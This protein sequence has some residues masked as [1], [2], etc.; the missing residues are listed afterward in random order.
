MEASSPSVGG[1]FT[2][3]AEVLGALP[4]VCHFF[5]RLGIDRRLDGAVA[6]SDPR[7]R[8][9]PGKALGV[10]VRN[11][12]LAHGPIY[13]LGEWAGRH[14]P[15]LLG[16]EEAE[17]ALVGDDRV[18]RA[19]L[20]LFDADRATMLN[21][22]VLDAVATFG[23]DVSQLHNDSTTVRLFGA[24]RDAKGASRV[25]KTTVTPARGHSKDFRPDL[26]QLVY[27]LTVA[28]DGAVPIAHR[29]ESGATEDS[30]T[31]IA[32]WDALCALLGRRDFLYIADSKLATRKN[33][34]HI[35]RG[36]G[37][38]VAVLP[39]S[40]KED[41]AFRAWLLDHEP[42][43][44]E[45]LRRPGR[46]RGDPDD[47]FATTEAPWPS[48]E[49]YRVVWVRSSDKV[50][51]D[52]ESR[53]S[54]IA[55]GIAALDHLNQ[56]LGSSK[57]RMKTSLVVEDAA[58]AALLS[59]GATRWVSFEV[60]EYEDVRHRQESR[61]RPGKDTRY[62]RVVRTRHRVHF[63]VREDIVV[64]DAASD[65]CWP[66]ITNDRELAAADLLVAYKH[67][68]HLERRHHILKADQVVAPVFLH[69]P[70]RIEAL[71]T[72]HFIALLVQ[73]LVE[74]VVRR[75]MAARGLTELALYPEDRACLAPSA[76]RIFEVFTGLARQHLYDADGRLVQSFSPKLNP[77]QR[78]ILD[79]LGVPADRY[80]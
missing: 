55:A 5:D 17:V 22:L 48:A 42:D 19:L 79:L 77:L 44:S 47:V 68:P 33:M 78:Q 69:D 27:I 41:G 1:P 57:T 21:S 32:T 38:F 45:A 52:A 54:R 10:L 53:R 62:R 59:A 9:A 28:A 3:S 18:G 65:G 73:A 75:A 25:G 43:W 11:V 60:E 39:A 56:R 4:I 67:Q 31:H 51:R 34:T 49:G 71:M 80:R 61:G 20:T 14:D 12:A 40:R 46:R 66:L 74:L 13:A 50:A 8:L 30:T 36:H 24:Y 26:L 72:C 29:V 16:L 37:R 15:A 7:V 58:R 76:A 23:V 6:N 63:R 70:A 2:L 64:A 35:D